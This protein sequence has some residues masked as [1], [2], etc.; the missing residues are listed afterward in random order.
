[1]SSWS[2]LTAL[3]GKLR[4]LGIDAYI[5]GSADPHQSEYPP[6]Y[7]E[8]RSWISGFTGS[9]GTVIVTA[10]HA[11]L[12]TDA[13]YFLQAEQQLAGT[14]FVL[15]KLRVQTQA[16]YVDW[17]IDRL[18]ANS[19]V[20]CD[21]WC[22]SLN[23][24][25]MFEKKFSQS[26]IVLKDSGD[27]LEGLWHHRPA[28]SSD[29]VYELDSSYAGQ[30]RAEKLSELRTIMAANRADFLLISALD[31]VAW[32]LNLR[33]SDVSYNP[34]FVSY[35]L[36]GKESC[37]LFILDGKVT[38]PIVDRLQKDGVRCVKYRSIE[39]RLKGLEAGKRVWIDGGSLNAKLS[40]ALPKQSL[41]V[42]DS[43]VMA[44]KSRKNE[45]E[46]RHI[47]RV[48]E[49]DGVALTKAFMW[50]ED[51]L[52]RDVRVSEFEFAEQIA[53]C[54]SQQETYIGESFA[55]IVGYGSNGAI[56]H[57]RPERDRCKDICAMGIL[58]VDSG[59]QYRDGTTDI[60]RTVALGPVSQEI[61]EQ[62]T[63]VLKGHI[64]LCKSIFPESTKGIQL[65]VLAR[66]FLWAKGLNYGHG[67]GHG[68][69][70]FLNVH[71]PPQGFVTVFN[72][73]GSTDFKAGMLTSNE[74]GHYVDGS[75]G[76][77]IENLM[78][79]VP[80]AKS[81]HGQFLQFEVVTLFPIDTTLI[82]MHDFGEEY[83]QWLNA[84]HREV[85]DR[86]SPYLNEDERRWLAG[87]TRAI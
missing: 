60:T 46:Q 79:T 21:F 29:P 13:R 70:F 85:Y 33:G 69:G 26:G 71:E 22:F 32:T 81:E 28:L 61:R 10:D 80:H 6:A 39:S 41:I 59:G 4:D 86:L 23:Q 73:R 82:S 1:M 7:W 47:R 75:H 30:S 56:V 5:I 48:M 15:H 18:P 24:V 16:E 55:A 3:R 87:K 62:Y 2:P 31:E 36:L 38:P 12:W 44:L 68:V 64:A 52:A 43:P 58:L 50:L 40:L 72:Q 84:Y 76:I 20:A 37:E 78:L 27:L 74:P 54:R 9:A 35:I 14:D 34:V 25:E 66:Q 51:C 49:R 83:V 77:R 53:A 57:Y 19:V 8:G 65:D 63:A 45:T 17:L 42:A 11:G 67:T